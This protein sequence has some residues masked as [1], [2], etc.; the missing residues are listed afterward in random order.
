[1]SD[2]SES[3]RENRSPHHLSGHLHLSGTSR[4]VDDMP[5]G[6]PKLYA[7]LLFSQ[8]AHARIVNV[9][10]TEAKKIVGISA[11]LTHHDIPGVN[12]IGHIQ[13]D[14]PLLAASEVLYIGQP[15]A[16][17]IAE[18]LWIAEQGVNAIQIE[19]EPL[20]P[21]LTIAEAIA[22]NS[23]FVQPRIIARGNLA[24]GFA[25][26]D[27]IV[28]ETLTTGGQE[29]FYLETQRC[30]A[31][32]GED[33]EITLY[34][35]TQSASEVQE[36]AARVLG[37]QC[38]DIV[39]DVPRIGGGFGGKE[40]SPV[41][42]SCLAALGCNRTG[43]PVELVLNRKEDMI[44]TGKRHPFEI[45]FRIGCK[46]DGRITAYEVELNANGGACVDL[47]LAILDRAMLHADNAYFLPNVKITGRAC[48]TNLPPNTAFR[49]F[50]APQGIFA[51]ETAIERIAEKLHLDPLTIRLR[52]LY[53]SGQTTPFG[54]IVQE[55][56]NRA[57]LTQ[58]TKDAK[59][60]ELL[61]DNAKFNAEHS[62]V[63]RG[64]SI[65]PI[66]FGISFTASFLNQASALVWI[67]QDGTVSLS[68]GGIEMGQALNT[69][70]A[71][72]VSAE[73]GI[74][75]S[76]IR[77]E[78]SN[79]KRVGNAS[80][81]AASSGSD[82]N[83]NAARTAAIELRNRLANVAAVKYEKEFHQS[84]TVDEIVFLDNQVYA[85]NFP[86]RV[87]S[88]VEIIHT[89]YLERVPLGAHGYYRTPDIFFDREKYHGSPFFYFV[90]GCGLVHVEIDLRNGN[91]RMLDVHLLHECGK[92][93]NP[94]IDRGQIVGAFT[95]G[96]GWCTME[97]L[98][99]DPEKGHYLAISPSTY[100]LP[101]IQDV[102]ERMTVEL[103]E[104]EREYASVRQSK[105]IGEPPLIYGEA[106]FF[107]IQNA[108][109]SIA[110]TGTP[111]K[112]SHPAT[113]EAILLAAEKLRDATN[114]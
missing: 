6:T 31:V 11:V 64:V 103:V 60:E 91:F 30:L 71:Q 54:E 81:T 7:K 106:C 92:S 73:L 62:D 44:A 57:L 43:K 12:Q 97:E 4:F 69:K 105:G 82:L 113:P 110:K 34:S 14:E 49:G 5:T 29:H 25:E 23:L 10:V 9:D 94:E 53:E 47:S 8:H 107:A 58:L 36:I 114:Q 104:C 100:K 41:L 22:R 26:A 85:T 50:G 27:C 75:L 61:A 40:R 2:N 99:Y 83:G 68:H 78:S 65:L 109:A 55:A 48:R 15:I 59:Y 42:W 88:F 52:N 67:Y 35:S 33:R 86:Q 32:P 84:V 66:K 13:P 74:S 16:I 46:Y 108:L 79:T 87:Y 37:L 20:E 24:D 63:K 70:V 72:V 80:P 45:R 102:P 21:V 76:H 95:Q 89:A 93:L 3:N 90:Y 112:L 96:V 56:S 19:Y 1:M 77:V 39:V 98:P 17:V 28:E 51:I 101:T 111:V 38:S 18:T